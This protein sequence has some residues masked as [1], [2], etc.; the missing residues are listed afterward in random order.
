MGDLAQALLLL[1]GRSAPI[2]IL[3]PRHGEKLAE[4]LLT[5]E[6]SARALDLGTCFRIPMDARDLHYGL[7]P[8]LLLSGGQ[9]FTSDGAAG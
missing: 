2:T 7:S 8:A 3:G 5:A 4:T 1:L 9:A 6:E